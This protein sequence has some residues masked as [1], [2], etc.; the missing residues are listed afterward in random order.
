MNL[1]SAFLTDYQNAT[2]YELKTLIMGCYADEKGVS[3]AKVRAALV[4][5]GLYM[6]KP[7]DDN[8]TKK[9]IVAAIAAVSGKQLP[10][11][12]N[13]SEKDLQTLWNFILEIDNYAKT[14]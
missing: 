5:L 13:A 3:V 11:L 12:V 1:D 14:K 9:G 7:K 10:T 4:S 2:T 6:S 8:E